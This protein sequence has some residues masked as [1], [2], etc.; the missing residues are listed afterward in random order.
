VIGQEY[1]LLQIAKLHDPPVQ[2]GRANLSIPYMLERG[3][4]CAETEQ[5]LRSL[6]QALESL[7]RTALR[8][9]RSRA[10]CHNDLETIISGTALGTFE[11]GLDR[12]YFDRLQAFV[13]LVHNDSIGGPYPFSDFAAADAADLMLAL[14]TVP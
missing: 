7:G 13:D 3:A 4:W 5:Q 10:L 2:N 9:A 6:A 14:R 11:A 1:T 12:A 8:T